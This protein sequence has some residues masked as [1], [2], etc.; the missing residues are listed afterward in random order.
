[1]EITTQQRGV[2]RVA[3]LKL[4]DMRSSEQ[5]ERNIEDEDGRGVQSESDGDWLSDSDDD[6]GRDQLQM[7][8][9][10]LPLDT[11]PPVPV[12][13]EPKTWD[14]SDPTQHPEPEYTRRDGFYHF[15]KERI[16]LARRRHVYK[17]VKADRDDAAVILQRT[18]RRRQRPKDSLPPA[19]YP[20]PTGSGLWPETLVALVMSE[21][22]KPLR[23][24]TVRVQVVLMGASLEANVDHFHRAILRYLTFLFTLLFTALFT[25]PS[26]LHAIVNAF[27]CSAAA[28]AA[29]TVCAKVF[30]RIEQMQNPFYL[31]RAKKIRSIKRRRSIIACYG[32]VAWT[33]EIVANIGGLFGTYLVAL[34][35][36]KFDQQETMQYYWLYAATVASVCN[37][38]LWGRVRRTAFIFQP[39]RRVKGG[40]KGFACA[41][42][43]FLLFLLVAAGGTLFCVFRHLP[44]PDSYT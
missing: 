40:S 2:D 1:M 29:H 42:L 35:W 13:D 34:Y 32:W 15:F 23:R 8:Q 20:Q 27:Q 30:Q 37:G 10:P 22:L 7:Q 33:L 19:V 43:Y 21:P 11:A 25:R 4:Q 41:D 31:R 28:T 38:V 5:K 18:W 39:L 14:T 16:G 9:K 24:L 26:K 3:R 6:G 12:T 44:H 17:A 36:L